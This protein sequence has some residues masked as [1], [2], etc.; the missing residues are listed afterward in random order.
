MSRHTKYAYQNCYTM[1]VVLAFARADG[2]AWMWTRVE[3]AYYQIFGKS[4]WS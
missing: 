1:W 4:L 3:M 2:D